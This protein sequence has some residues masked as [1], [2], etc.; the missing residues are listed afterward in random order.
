[1][2]M[3]YRHPITVLENFNTNMQCLLKY[4]FDDMG[5][6]I[7]GR[8]DVEKIMDIITKFSK[9]EE[10]YVYSLPDGYE[11]FRD[12]P[13]GGFDY[14]EVLEMYID[15]LFCHF[16]RWIVMKEPRIRWDDSYRR[17]L[18]FILPK[19]DKEGFKK[20]KKRRRKL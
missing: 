11:S 4:L 3:E 20:F 17:F 6:A 12:L 10:R 18:T 16:D 13:K 2:G 5:N 7:V 15:T 1:M 14:D 19:L 8:C 9:W